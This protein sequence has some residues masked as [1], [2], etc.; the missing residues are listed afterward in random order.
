MM[1]RSKRALRLSANFVIKS[2]S[3]PKIQINLMDLVPCLLAAME[4]KA[5]L[6]RSSFFPAR[7]RLTKPFS[8]V[9]AKLFHVWCQFKQ[10]SGFLS[11]VYG[12]AFRMLLRLRNRR[13]RGLRVRQAP[14]NPLFL[15]K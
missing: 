5:D 15:K 1:L 2:I 6:F 13:S 11:Q 8:V 10:K 3:D 9:N 4:A 7:D 14:S 12:Y